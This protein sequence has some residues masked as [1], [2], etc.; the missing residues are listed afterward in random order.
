MNSLKF[1]SERLKFR[2]FRDTD[3]DDLFAFLSTQEVCAYLPGEE[4]YN[5]LQVKKWLDYFIRTFDETK[6]NLIYAVTS[7]NQDEV[8]GY[9]GLAYVKEFEQNEI[10]Y[11]FHPN[12]WGKG[13]ATEA[14]SKMKEMAQSLHIEKLIGLTD[15]NNIASERVLLKIGYQFVKYLEI[16]GLQMK[17]FELNLNIVDKIN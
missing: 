8:I 11:A 9:V 14:A 6:P 4:P 17:Y 5:A 12:V 13:Y 3:F 15:I 1:E 16:W 7:K 2:Q 10:M